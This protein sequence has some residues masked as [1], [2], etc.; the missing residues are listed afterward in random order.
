[1]VV[2]GEAYVYGIMKGG[3]WEAED[4]TW[5]EPSSQPPV[6]VEGDDLEFKDIE[7]V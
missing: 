1:M 2:T 6:R 4:P 7:L 3:L 5:L